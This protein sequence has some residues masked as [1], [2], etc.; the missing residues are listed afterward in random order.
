MWIEIF[1][2]FDMIGINESKLIYNPFQTVDQKFDGIVIN[3]YSNFP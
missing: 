3:I 1:L 2:L